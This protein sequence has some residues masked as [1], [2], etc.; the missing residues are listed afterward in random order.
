MQGLGVVQGFGTSMGV[1]VGVGEKGR[2]LM[3]KVRLRKGLVL[4][5]LFSLSC[6]QGFESLV[7]L[8]HLL[9]ACPYDYSLSGSQGS[10][11]YCFCGRYGYGG[12]LQNLSS[13]YW[14]RMSCAR[15]V[16]HRSCLVTNDMVPADVVEKQAAQKMI[17]CRVRMST[18]LASLPLRIWTY[19][20]GSR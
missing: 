20:M 6:F 18:L 10:K 1:V 2:T 9:Y 3:P 17:Y 5:M 12:D 4:E 15:P 13:R 8:L 11:F 16:S 19:C 7:L 14:Q